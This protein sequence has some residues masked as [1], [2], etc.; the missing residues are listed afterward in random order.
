MGLWLSIIGPFEWPDT[1]GASAENLKF[2]GALLDPELTQIVGG[3]DA[4]TF[5]FGS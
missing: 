4:E 2:Y 1:G 5:G 3:W